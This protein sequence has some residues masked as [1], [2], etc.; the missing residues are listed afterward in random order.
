MSDPQPFPYNSNG[1]SS[2]EDVVIVYDD[3]PGD[4]TIRPMRP[5][6]LRGWPR[7]QFPR[8]EARAGSRAGPAPRSEEDP[9]IPTPV[10]LGL[11]LCD[12]VLVEQGTKKVSYIR[13]FRRLRASGFPVVMSPFFVC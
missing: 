1:K 3:G 13:S 5:E 6:I 10:A 2:A 8:S 9:M 4:H 11:T 7:P 12:Y